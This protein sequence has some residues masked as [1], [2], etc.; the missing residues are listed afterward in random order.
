MEPRFQVAFKAMEELKKGAIANPNK[1]RMVGHYW[2]RNSKLA[3]NK[4]LQQQIENT[5]DAICKFADEIISG[6]VRL[7]NFGDSSLELKLQR[8]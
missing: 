7:S 4:F 3:L 2:L 5:L 8:V 6:K 1:G